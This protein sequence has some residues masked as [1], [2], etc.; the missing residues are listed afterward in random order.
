MSTSLS[1]C[2]LCQLSTLEREDAGYKEVMEALLVC[3]NILE[4]MHGAGTP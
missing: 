2:K 1:R 3:A 4:T